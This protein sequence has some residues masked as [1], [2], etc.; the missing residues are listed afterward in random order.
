MKN[1][2]RNLILVLSLSLFACAENL[3]K[4]I[5]GDWSFAKGVSN[6][7][8]LVLDFSACE[9]SF[10]EDTTYTLSIWGKTKKGKWEV[11]H[12]KNIPKDNKAD[13]GVVKLDNV[14]YFLYWWYG[15]KGFISGNINPKDSTLSHNAQTQIYKR[16]EPEKVYGINLI[17]K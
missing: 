3:E 1:R 16:E 7:S 14:V 12:D 13:M 5:V 8:D 15:D 10:N 6:K 4:D 11:V 17:K 9:I 2:L